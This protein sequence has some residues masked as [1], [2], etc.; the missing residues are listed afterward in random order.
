MAKARRTGKNS[1]SIA[2]AFT[3]IKNKPSKKEFKIIL[4]ILQKKIQ[5][6]VF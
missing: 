4:G 5:G 6:Y 1:L 2:K 3:E